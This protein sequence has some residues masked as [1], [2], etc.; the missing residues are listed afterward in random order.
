MLND[1]TL[2]FFLNTESTVT[3]M[4][5]VRRSPFLERTTIA[6]RRLKSTPRQAGH[7]ADA[8]ALCETPHPCHHE[9]EKLIP[10]TFPSTYA[11]PT[12]EEIR[13][14]PQ[15]VLKLGLQNHPEQ[16]LV[17]LEPPQ[18]LERVIL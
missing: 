16:G 3:L 1:R 8:I 13:G 5:M 9:Y 2:L 18:F 7:A 10:Y 11:A 6:V 15:T 4:G 12:V 17:G 14:I